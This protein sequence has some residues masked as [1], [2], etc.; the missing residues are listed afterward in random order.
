M[1]DVILFTQIILSLA[2]VTL[3]EIN[4]SAV[5]NFILVNVRGVRIMS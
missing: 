3:I 4:P 2:D 5:V 1:E